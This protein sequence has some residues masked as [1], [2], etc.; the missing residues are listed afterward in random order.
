MWSIILLSLSVLLLLFI[1]LWNSNSFVPEKTTNT[2]SGKS[3]LKDFKNLQDVSEQIRNHVAETVTGLENSYKIFNQSI[4]QLINTKLT[5]LS[6]AMNRVGK[7]ETEIVKQLSDQISKV[8]TELGEKL[9]T[10]DNKISVLLPTL[11]DRSETIQTTLDSTIN[12]KLDIMEVAHT[13]INIY[14]QQ[15]LEQSKYQNTH[16]EIIKSESMKH[17]KTSIASEEFGK[18]NQ[19]LGAI[20]KIL[21]HACRIDEILQGILEKEKV[22]IKIDENLK[23]NVILSLDNIDMHTL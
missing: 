10:L 3:V 22:I 1:I 23:D 2:L 11:I 14:I 7:M 8:E 19:K 13:G 12:Q 5:E 6:D 15:M 20:P 21:E 16:I 4:V 18:L 9:Q 17:L